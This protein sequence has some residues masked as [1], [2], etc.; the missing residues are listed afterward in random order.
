MTGD[1]KPRRVEHRAECAYDVQASPDQVWAAIATAEGISSWMVPTRLDPRI[2]GQ[3]VFD[4]GDFTSTGVVTGYTPNACF[5]YQEPWPIADRKEDIPPRM[6][7][8][9]AAL[10]I[11]LPEVYEGLSHVSPI[12]TEFLIEAA[13][14][15]SC[16]VRV[17]TSSYGSGA[18]WE[19]EFFAEMVAGTMPI[20]DR[21]AASFAG[22]ATR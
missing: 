2:G 19:N 18:D 14:G 5:S 11:S 20:W 8:W 21:L 1:E 15:G 4:L 10:G 9:F 12:A 3:V 7:E 17:V 16:V 13:S 6:I 22:A